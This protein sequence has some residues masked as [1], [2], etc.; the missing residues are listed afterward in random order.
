[1]NWLILIGV[2]FII[3]FALRKIRKTQEGELLTLKDE[4]AIEQAKGDWIKRSKKN[5]VTH[6]PAC[7]VCH[8]DLTDEIPYID[9]GFFFC[10]ECYI[11]QSV[12][13]IHREKI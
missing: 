4:L 12:K 3:Q 10:D 6:Y 5:K 2:F 8:K 7:A 13:K 11:E 9:C 1:M